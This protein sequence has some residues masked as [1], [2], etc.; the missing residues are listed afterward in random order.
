MCIVGTRGIGKPGQV[1]HSIEMLDW[2]VYM[3]L[4]IEM[5]HYAL[6]RACARIASNMV[7][8]STPDKT[9]MEFAMDLNSG[10]LKGLW[11]GIYKYTYSG[12]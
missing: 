8:L 2:W 5:S 3:L 12:G 9:S 7:I 6:T 11:Y 1:G 10:V 4:I